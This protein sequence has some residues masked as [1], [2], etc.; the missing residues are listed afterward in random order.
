[1]PVAE[2]S[3]TELELWMVQLG[4]PRETQLDMLPGN[5]IGI[6]SH[7][8]YHPFC[9][10][11]FKK[12][13]HIQK[14]VALWLAEPTTDA[15][16]QFYMD[17][18]FMQASTLDYQHPNKASDRVVTSFDGFTAYLLIVDEALHHKWEFLTS[19][20][21]PPLDLI[22]EFLTRF[23]HPDSGSIRTER[24]TCRLTEAGGHGALAI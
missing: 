23:G 12:Q 20:K 5:V 6:P 15:H 19:T 13:A 1:V 3:Q 2:A 22:D 8:E 17:Y 21:D 9:Y 10:T 16:K 7:F 24:R 11:D 4:C 14:Q 18:G